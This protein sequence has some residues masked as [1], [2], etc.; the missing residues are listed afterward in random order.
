MQ[1]DTQQKQKPEG[2]LKLKNYL[3]CFVEIIL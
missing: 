2:H 3:H 1:F